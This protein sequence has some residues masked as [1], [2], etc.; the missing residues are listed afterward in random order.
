VALRA[1]TLLVALIWGTAFGAA[2]AEPA[3]TVPFRY[4]D[5]RI[6]IQ[7]NVNGE[8]FTFVVDTGA[9]TT[10]VT[11]QVARTLGLRT[12]SA[13]TTSGVG[14]ATQAV[15]TT[16]LHSLSIGKRAFT[17]V[18]SLVLDLSNIRD[19]IGFLHFDGVIGY[20]L[21]HA[22]ALDVD[23]DRLTLTLGGQA[24][25]RRGAR[26]VPFS[27]SLPHV[28]ATI[29]GIPGSVV[30]DTGDRS[31]LTLFKRF[32]EEHG[33][34][35]TPGA[36]HDVLTGFGIGGPVYGDVFR[37][38]TLGMFG[39]Q[40]TGVVTRASRQRAGAFATMPDAGSVGGGVL[41]RFNITYDY[42][43]SELS[44]TPSAYRTARDPY[45][46]SGMWLSRAGSRIVVTAVT[47]AGPAEAAGLRGGDEIV[48]IDGRRVT[49][50]QVIQVRAELATKSAGS[51]VTVG[52]LRG[53]ATGTRVVTLV[54]LV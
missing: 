6:M 53:G 12:T 15:Q 11:P 40:V 17:N 16:T 28:K 32:A 14:N 10:S 35:A 45:D 19:H 54:D 4:V 48:S 20:S 9:S 13:G 18:S 42:P 27:G 25:R 49:S 3:T 51:R 47:L 24:V 33:Y 30:L 29:D 34:Y 39:T 7:V 38:E 2:G 8:P 31:S 1:R 41:R 36:L 21:L 23:S 52:Y 22:F 26:I 37:L 5:N 44:V 46:R 43:R 50:A